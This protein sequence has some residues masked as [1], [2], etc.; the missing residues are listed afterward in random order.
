MSVPTYSL[1]RNRRLN[2][3]AAFAAVFRF[4]HQARSNYVQICAKPNG[5]PYSRLG[6]IVSKKVERGSVKRNWI[7][8]LFRETFRTFQVNNGTEQMDW[9][10]RLRRP[11]SAD[12]ATEFTAEVR[13]LMHQLQKCHD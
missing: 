12:I 10:M 1:P 6:L 5:L 4:Q 8:R 11:V 7:K 9:V 2:D 3:A 13:L